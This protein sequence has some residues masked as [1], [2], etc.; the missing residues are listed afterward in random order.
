M[1]S[2]LIKQKTEIEAITDHVVFCLEDFIR[3]QAKRAGFSVSGVSRISLYVHEPAKSRFFLLSK[4]ILQY[5]IG[6][7]GMN[8]FRRSRRMYCQSLGA[9]LAF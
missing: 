4:K 7:K 6:E 1:Q 2:A 3:E 9:G 5:Q 8:F